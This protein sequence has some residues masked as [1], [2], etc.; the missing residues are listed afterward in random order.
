MILA[1]VGPQRKSRFRIDRTAKSDRNRREL[2][3]SLRGRQSLRNILRTCLA[4]Q[5]IKTD[6]K[7]TTRKSTIY[8]SSFRIIADSQGPESTFDSRRNAAQQRQSH[9]FLRH[10]DCF[11]RFE[12]ADVSISAGRC[13]ETAESWR[14][15][16]II[17]R[18]ETLS[19]KGP[20][21]ETHSYPDCIAGVRDA[22]EF[23]FAGG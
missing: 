15:R 3:D 7:T 5:W 20:T 16:S 18:S 21:D 6:S 17:L 9:G 13:I 8:A 11:D 1:H 2:R 4:R 12:Y 22:C 10:F 19:G 14:Y 23:A